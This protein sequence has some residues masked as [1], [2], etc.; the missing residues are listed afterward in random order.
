[1]EN[2]AE[3]VVILTG[4][5]GGIGEVIAEAF[6]QAGAR[7]GLCDIRTENLS[8]TADKCRQHGA[9]VYSSDIDVSDEDPV[10]SFCETVSKT[11]GRIDCLINTVGIVDCPGDVQS[12]PLS[13]WNRT[14]AVNLTSAFLMAKYAVPH[15]KPH[16]GAILNI[17]SVSGLANQEQEMVYSVTKAALLSLTRSEAID[18]AKHGIRANAISPG[19][20]ETPLL[21]AAVNQNAER[22]GRTP[23]DQWHLWRSQ[24]PTQRFTSPQEIAELAL[25]LCSER[26]ANITGANFTIDGG[27]MALLPE[28]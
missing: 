21:E 7:L 25:F 5:C 16:G 20:V 11:F 3:K 28:R 15:M 1:M 18:L 26:A 10:R 23:E 12:L 22:F 8:R 17:A 13:M 27:L 2:Y 9:S 24:Y 6:A 4:A 19:S 14:L